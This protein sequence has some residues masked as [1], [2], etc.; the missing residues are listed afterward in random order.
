MA[1][2]KR[3]MGTASANLITRQSINDAELVSAVATAGL[4]KSMCIHA[5]PDHPLTGITGPRCTKPSALRFIRP[6]V[7]NTM[8][9][10]R[11]TSA[12]LFSGLLR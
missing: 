3:N 8:V 9:S 7:I 5:Y 6:Q 1:F 4:H 2:Q 11:Y 12:N 10:N